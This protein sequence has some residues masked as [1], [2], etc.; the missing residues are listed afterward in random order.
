LLVNNP[1]DMGLFTK[2][3]CEL[4]NGHPFKT[5]NQDTIEDLL[6]STNDEQI[7]WKNINVSP[8]Y[9]YDFAS[10]GWQNFV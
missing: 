3:Q 8:D 1:E 5:E 4:I 10:E 9:I 6:E 7:F 2:E